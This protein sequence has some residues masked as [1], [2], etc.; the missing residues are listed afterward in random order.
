MCPWSSHVLELFSSFQSALKTLD[1]LYLASVIMNSI[2]QFG[3]GFCRLNTISWCSVSVSEWDYHL[4]LWTH[5]S[6][7]VP[8]QGWA[9]CN[10]LRDCTEQTTE[11]QEIHSLYSCFTV[12]ARTSH[13][14]SSAWGLGFIPLPSWFSGLWIQIELHPQSFPGSLAYRQQIVGLLSLLNHINN[15]FI[16]NQSLFPLP[17]SLSLL[18]WFSL[19]PL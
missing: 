9:N 5:W 10:P 16:I 15:I 11:K 4:N 18:L 12:W 2:C 13:V 14:T 8:Q 7:S 1:V 17:L 6:S 19:S 3:H